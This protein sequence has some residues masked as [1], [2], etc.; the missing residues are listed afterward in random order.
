MN[1]LPS[2]AI[3][4]SL[5]QLV[6]PEL[7][8]IFLLVAIPAFAVLSIILN[9]RAKGRRQAAPL[10]PP[11]LPVDPSIVER[12]QHLERRKQGNYISE[13]EYEEARRKIL[14]EG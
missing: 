11:P 7:I 2:P 13:S 3:V 4:A 8:I 10:S 1:L 12:L 9:F 14:E 5:F 6:G